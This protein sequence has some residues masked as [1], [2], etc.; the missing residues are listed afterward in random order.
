MRM[1]FYLTI[2]RYSFFNALYSVVL[3]AL[4]IV[5]LS[6][7]IEEG[8]TKKELTDNDQPLFFIPDP[9]RYYRSLKSRV[10]TSRPSLTRAALLPSIQDLTASDF[11][12][13]NR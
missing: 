4:A 5:S 10:N 3:Q 7:L 8:Y 12:D 2:I 1:R 11:F 9:D 6:S 13:R